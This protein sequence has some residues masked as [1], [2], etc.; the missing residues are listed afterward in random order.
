MATVTDRPTIPMKGSLV[1][2]TCGRCGERKTVPYQMEATV[3]DEC[4]E[5]A[6][7]NEK[8]VTSDGW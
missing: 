3:C 8:G 5:A 6:V 2:A 4:I 7:D 1:A